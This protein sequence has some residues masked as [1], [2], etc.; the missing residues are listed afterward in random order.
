M[1]LMERSY[2]REKNMYSLFAKLSK[3]MGRIA[4]FHNENSCKKNLEDF[5]ALASF[6]GIQNVPDILTSLKD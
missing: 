3:V 1:L 4:V 6:T 5:R 2:L